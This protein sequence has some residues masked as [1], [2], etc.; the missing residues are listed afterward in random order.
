MEADHLNLSAAAK[1]LQHDIVGAGITPAQGLA[2]RTPS[3][4]KIDYEKSD[5]GGTA[6]ILIDEVK[7]YIQ[8]DPLPVDPNLPEET[9]QFTVRAILVGCA[10]GA[11]VRA[12]STSAR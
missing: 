10:I 6:S 5:L 12:V 2:T 3:D 7:P 1:P 4:E 9:N 11:V 8:G